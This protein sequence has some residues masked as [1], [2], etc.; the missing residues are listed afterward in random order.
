MHGLNETREPHRI[1]ELLER[2]GDLKEQF[3]RGIG[4]QTLGVSTQALDVGERMLSQIL[5]SGEPSRCNSVLRR[6]LIYVFE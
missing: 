1:G 3:D 4:V 6:S 5:S 2:F